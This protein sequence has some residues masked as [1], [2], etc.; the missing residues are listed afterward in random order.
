MFKPMLAMAACLALSGCGGAGGPGPLAAGQV[1]RIARSAGGLVLV[2]FDASLTAFD[3]EIDAGAIKPE[4]AR[5]IAFVV[6]HVSH[7]VALAED[8]RRIGEPGNYTKAFED[9]R[10]G[11][12]DLGLL[13]GQTPIG[14]SI[15]I[16]A[17]STLLEAAPSLSLGTGAFAMPPETPA[18]AQ[19]AAAVLAHAGRV[20][21]R[22]RE[23]AAGA[24]D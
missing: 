2:G 11:L 18:E 5:R 19:R 14:V 22:L 20:V 1:A 9:I 8:A 23:I 16:S 21:T 17:I 12:V 3:A 6:E 4:R 15:A 7:G 10:A 24:V 13:K